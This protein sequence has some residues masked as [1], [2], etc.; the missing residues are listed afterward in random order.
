MDARRRTERLQPRTMLLWTN[1]PL[2]RDTSRIA[3]APHA[4]VELMEVHLRDKRRDVS[5]WA[6]MV[7]NTRNPLGAGVA[8]W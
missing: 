3:Q 6:A 5:C 7:G 4:G 1:D 2:M 8:D